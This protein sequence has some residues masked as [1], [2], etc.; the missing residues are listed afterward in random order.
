MNFRIMTKQGANLWSFYTEDGFL[1][2]A[3]TRLECAVKFRE[4]AEE[5]PLGNMVAIKVLEPDVLIELESECPEPLPEPEPDPDAPNP[6]DPA[7]PD[8]P[9]TPPNPENPD[10][11]T[12]PD[13]D[14]G[15]TTP[16][17]TTPD[18]T[19]P[20]ETTENTGDTV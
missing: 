11:V 13:P 7:S 3:Q 19:T 16:E 15:T 18:I 9:V 8:D 5:I 17:P 4:L 12:P 20:P 1:W 10:P 6:D 2:E 14:T